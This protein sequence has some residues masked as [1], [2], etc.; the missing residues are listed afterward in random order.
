MQVLIN[1]L[2]CNDLYNNKNQV[3]AS[4]SL[5]LRVLSLH[6]CLSVKLVLYT[7]HMYLYQLLHLLC[8]FVSNSLINKFNKT[9]KCAVTPRLV[10]SVQI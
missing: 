7:E 5:T 8:L 2:I 6:V 1:R 4:S 9:K 10:L 3:T